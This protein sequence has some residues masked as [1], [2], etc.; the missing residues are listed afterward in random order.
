MDYL[1]IELVAFTDSF[2]L[3]EKIMD[4]HWVGLINPIIGEQV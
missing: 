1:L 3:F 2:G 4:R